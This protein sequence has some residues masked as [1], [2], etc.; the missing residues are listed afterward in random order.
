MVSNLCKSV[1]SV[2]GSLLGSQ[3]EV[4]GY[5]YDNGIHFNLLKAYIKPSSGISDL[6]GAFLMN[7]LSYV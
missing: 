6:M 1:K 4:Q 5:G 2:D 3:G 7:R